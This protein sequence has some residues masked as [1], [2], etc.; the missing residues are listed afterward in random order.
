MSETAKTK[1]NKLMRG[2]YTNAPPKGELRSVKTAWGSDRLQ[3]SDE[4][5]DWRDTIGNVEVEIHESYTGGKI[6][7]APVGTWVLVVEDRVDT[8]PFA[9]LR[10]A[11]AYAEQSIA[12]AKQFDNQ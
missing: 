12:Y 1:W 2:W 10:D 5:E 8:E 4:Y 9:T 7:N 3:F 11:K 6:A